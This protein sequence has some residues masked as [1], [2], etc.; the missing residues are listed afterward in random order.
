[1]RNPG[2][3]R[4]Q[5][6]L[7]ICRA[8]GVEPHVLRYWEREFRSIRPTKSAKGQRVYSRREAREL[9][10]DF[11]EVKLRTFFLN[12]RFLPV[13]GSLLPRSIESQLGARWG[14]HLWIYAR[15]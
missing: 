4:N 15:K 11:S 5:W 14:W 6:W 12:K 13:I 8:N 9:F 10:R 7:K 3:P 1:M 2:D